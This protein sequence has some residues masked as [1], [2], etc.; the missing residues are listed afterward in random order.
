MWYINNITTVSNNLFSVVELTPKLL[1]AQA[2]IFFVAGFETSSTTI[3]NT[4]YELALNQ[5]VQKK[6]R[7]EIKEFEVKNGGEWKYE[8]IKQMKYLHKVFQGENVTIHFVLSLTVQICH[9][10]NILKT[11]NFSTFFE[12]TH[13]VCRTEEK[14]SHS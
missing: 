9:S 14:I 4:L 5:E 8:T 6:L 3:S 1:A 11:Y 13:M 7:E 12:K 10:S 2:F